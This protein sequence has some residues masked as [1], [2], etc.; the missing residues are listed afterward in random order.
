MIK[1]LISFL[2][3]ISSAFA[4]GSLAGKQVSLTVSVKG[5]SQ[6]Q[7][8]TSLLGIFVNAVFENGIFFEPINKTMKISLPGNCRRL[9]ELSF[10]Q[11]VLFTVSGVV[12]MHLDYFS[13]PTLISF[14]ETK[15]VG[16][17]IFKK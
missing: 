17:E 11:D 5:F 9:A 10:S 8:V 14:D 15:T 1:V 4:D 13:Q 7:D 2:F 6:N 16:C 3:L 12:K